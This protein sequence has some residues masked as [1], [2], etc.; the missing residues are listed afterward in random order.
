MLA[1]GLWLGAYRVVLIVGHGIVSLSRDGRTWLQ[2][3]NSGRTRRAGRRRERGRCR[4]SFALRLHALCHF[5]F[6]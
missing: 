4:C 1:G 6:E 2:S 3:W 5:A